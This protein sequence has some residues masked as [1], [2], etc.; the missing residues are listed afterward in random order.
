MATD[1]FL[2]QRT[3]GE[4]FEQFL[5]DAFNKKG[6]K[7][8]KNPA[9]LWREKKGWDFDFALN[10]QLYKVEAKLDK[11]SVDTGNFCFDLDSLKDTIA[12]Y[13][14]HGIPDKNTY[15][16][17]MITVPELK[18]FC[19]AIGA[20]LRGGEFKLPLCVIPKDKALSEAHFVPIT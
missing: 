14:I 6:L 4:A 18:P 10:N 11:M 19:G 3:E 9:T 1:W 13:W 7:A 5:I 12:D 17:W 2:Q 8:R 15:H 20:T 16:A